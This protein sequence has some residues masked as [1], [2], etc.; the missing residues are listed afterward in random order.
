MMNLWGHLRK[1]LAYLAPERSLVSTQAVARKYVAVV[2]ALLAVAAIAGAVVLSPARRSP[3][4][5]WSK[6]R[7]R[8]AERAQIDL[9]DDFSTGLDSW[10]SRESLASTWSYDKNGFVN[11]GT[12]SLLAPSMHLTNYDVDALVQIEAKGVGLAFRAASD[13]NYHAVRLIVEGRGPVSTLALEHYVVISGRA[14]LPIRVRYSETFQQDTLYRV[15]LEVRDNAFSLYLQG[16]LVDF[17][18]DAQLAAGGVGL[19]CRSGERA[20]IAWIR[21]SHNTDSLGRM[22]S[23]LCSML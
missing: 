19:F 16:K 4:D 11:P 3:S 7:E 23:L 6:L 9:F 2:T 8:V 17:W 14:S 22:C 5:P 12:L 10:Q 1:L 21:V 18:S 20:R 15:H 13:R